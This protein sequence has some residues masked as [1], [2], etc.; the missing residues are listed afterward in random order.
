MEALS[1]TLK[2]FIGQQFHANGLKQEFK[3]RKKPV[4]F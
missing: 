4:T 1:G 2:I 3:V